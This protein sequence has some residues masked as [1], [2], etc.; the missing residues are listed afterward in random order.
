MALYLSWNNYENRQ[1]LIHS[2]ASVQRT[3][4]LDKIYLDTPQTVYQYAYQ[5]LTREEK[6]HGKDRQGQKANVSHSVR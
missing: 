1:R 4:T 6:H 3:A 5:L 2:A